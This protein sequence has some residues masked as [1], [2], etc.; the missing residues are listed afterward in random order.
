MLEKNK[1]EKK[2]RE[3]EEGRE[4]ERE[5]GERGG[6]REISRTFHKFLN[7]EFYLYIEIRTKS[8]TFLEKLKCQSINAHKANTL[9]FLCV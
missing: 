3:R 1:K 7:E 8:F 6:K 4:E 2:E 9:C 5:R